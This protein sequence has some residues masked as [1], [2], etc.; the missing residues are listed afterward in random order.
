VAITLRIPPYPPDEWIE[1]PSYEAKPD[2]QFFMP[3]AADLP[4][5]SDGTLYNF[6]LR[7]FA[8]MCRIRRLHSEILTTMRGLSPDIDTARLRE[9][10]VE[11]DRWTKSDEVFANGYVFENLQLYWAADNKS[12]HPNREGHASPLGVVYVGHM[13]RFLL[14]S[15]VSL[16]VS[17]EIVDELLQACCDACATFRALQKRKHLPRHWFDV[18][19]PTRKRQQCTNLPL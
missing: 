4:G 5:F 10:R 6:D 17:S 11:I 7:Y 1:T 13:T 3:W 2:P 18:R 12:S 8:H 16:E 19:Y 14:Y 15:S 9:L